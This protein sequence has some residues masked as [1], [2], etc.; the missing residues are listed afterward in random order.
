[1]DYAIEAHNGYGLFSEVLTSNI[2]PTVDALYCAADGTGVGT[3]GG[4]RFYKKLSGAMTIR[5][6]P[7]NL[8]P[9]IENNNGTGGRDIIDT[10]NG[11]VRYV[12]TSGDTMTGL[13][14]LSGDP[15]TTNQAATKH[16]VDVTVALN[17]LWQ[18]TYTVRTNTPDLTVAGVPITMDG[19]GLL[20][21]RQ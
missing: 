2:S 13:L 9:Q 7:A 1:L 11:D 8:Q 19:L 15:A 14:T 5:S 4:G 3:W 16:Y 20:L 17:S 18:G 21:L 6:G 12:N 10:I